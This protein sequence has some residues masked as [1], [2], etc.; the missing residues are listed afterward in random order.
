MIGFSGTLRVTSFESIFICK[1]ADS[2]DDG[3]DV[4]ESLN[5]DREGEFDDK[6]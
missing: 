3:D 5:F 2:D 6:V 4:V 1:W